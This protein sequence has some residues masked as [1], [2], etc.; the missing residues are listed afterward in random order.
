M[1]QNIAHRG[2]KNRENTLEGIIKANTM[3]SMVEIDVR[4][5][6]NHDIILCHDREDRNFEIN[7]TLEDLLLYEDTSLNLMIDIKAFGIEPALKI[8]KDVFTL[9]VK[10]PKHDYHLCSFN[11]FCVEK[12]LNLRIVYQ[13]VCQIGVI[14]SGIPLDM[15]DHLCNIDFISL[16]YNIIC[17]DIVEMFH[18]KNIKVFAWTVNSLEMQKYVLD[19]CHVDSIIY[20][21]FD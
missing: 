15:F 11:E 5:N 14:S 4:F 1:T 12:L 7:E 9:I 19:I 2:M 13:K 18:K 8:A 10:Y 17:E 16:D 6:T 3:M 20:D 21:I